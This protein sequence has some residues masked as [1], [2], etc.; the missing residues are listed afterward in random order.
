VYTPSSE[1]FRFYLKGYFVRFLNSSVSLMFRNIVMV[2]SSVLLSIIGHSCGLKCYTLQVANLEVE[3]TA[4]LFGIRKISDS[5]VIPETRY[6]KDFLPFLKT[7]LR[8][9]AQIRSQVIPPPTSCAVPY[10]QITLPFAV[11]QSELMILF[12]LASTVQRKPW[13]L[14]QVTNL[15][16]FFFLSPLLLLQL[17]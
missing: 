8:R 17:L 9:R 11:T 7:L 12:L 1:S 6:P 3:W 10:S 15:P 14:L 2:K 16:N 13:P 4:V 5:N